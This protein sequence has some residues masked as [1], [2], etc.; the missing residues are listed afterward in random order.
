MQGFYFWVVS[1]NI[2]NL[3]QVISGNSEAV[4]QRKLGLYL[5]NYIIRS[6]KQETDIN[7]G[8]SCWNE[9]DCVSANYKAKGTD[10]SLCELNSKTLEELPREAQN[11][12]EYVYLEVSKRV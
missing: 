3:F 7:C 6:L 2:F 1:V 8:I 12:A 4:F 10:K 11:R 5:G 9:P